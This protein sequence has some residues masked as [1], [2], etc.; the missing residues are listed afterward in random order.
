MKLKLYL[1]LFTVTSLG[2]LSCKTASKLYE[3]GNY[4]EAVEIAAKKLQ[5]DPD[6]PKL[7]DIITNSYQYAVND[8]ESRIRSLS[9]S[10]NEL[11]WEWM[12]NEYVSLQKLYDAIYK[13]PAVLEI[14]KPINYTDYLVTYRQKAGDIRYERGLAFMQRYTKQSYKDAYREFQQALHFNPGD[15]DA[16][17]KLDEAYEYAVTNVVVLPMQQQGG[18]VY[19]SYNIGGNN[20]DDQ[21]LRSL[22]YYSGNEFVKFYSA[23]DAR[24]RQI[25]VDQEVLMQLGTIDIGRQ[26]DNRSNR[27]VSKEIV[28]KEIVY[29]P[30]SIVKEYARVHANIITTRRTMSS[31]VMLQV[32]IR[33]A[34]GRWLWN[35]NFTAQHN[36]VTE[37]AT[38]NGDERALSDSDKLLVNRRQEFAPTESEIMRLLLE[39]ISNNA[40]YRIKNYF[41][42]F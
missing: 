23:W 5:K 10:N 35:D 41:N 9:L 38:Y 36:W 8:H 18:Y 14:V 11:K 12:Y 31:N 17:L 32:N 27:K 25:R 19:S 22:Q 2:I 28:V 39:E 21:L 33:D 1:L 26:H 30:D 3:K 42:R 37:F 15:T 29:R 7:L 40:E 24:S 6:D 34:D 13:V 20:L 4:D 16:K